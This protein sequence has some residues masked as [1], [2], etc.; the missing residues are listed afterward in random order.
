MNGRNPSRQIITPNLQKNSFD[1]GNW[2]LGTTRIGKITPIRWD[3]V[4]PNSHWRI[5]TNWRCKLA[6]VVF[7]FN[8]KIDGVVTTAFMP[9]RL[10]MPTG[11]DTYPDWA[12]WIMGDPQDR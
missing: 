10:M 6:P 1:I 12:N 9:Y 11:K 7:P 2:W 3:D 8:H 5:K 4:T